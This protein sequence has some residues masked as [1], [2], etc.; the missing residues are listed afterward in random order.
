MKRFVQ[1]SA[2]CRVVGFLTFWDKATIKG[3]VRT[4]IETDQAIKRQAAAGGIGLS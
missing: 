2:A 3:W 4:A 1:L